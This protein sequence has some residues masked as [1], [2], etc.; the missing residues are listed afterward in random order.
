M[1]IQNKKCS[2]KTKLF[3]KILILKMLRNNTQQVYILLKIEGKKGNTS[4]RLALRSE[5]KSGT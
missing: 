5:S 2:Q 1:V 3:L 4:D